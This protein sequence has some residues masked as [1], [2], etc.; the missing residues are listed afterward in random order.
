MPDIHILDKEMFGP[1]EQISYVGKDYLS[2]KTVVY[3]PDRGIFGLS[4]QIN[5]D[6]QCYLSL[7]IDIHN[8][9]IEIVCPHELPG[10]VV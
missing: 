9:N 10:C 5:Y 2:L 8:L 7:L 4:V 3:I 1:Y 6:F